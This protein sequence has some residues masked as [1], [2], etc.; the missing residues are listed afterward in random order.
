MT[1]EEGEMDKAEYIK[2]LRFLYNKALS[3]KEI[4]L[5]LDVLDR[6]ASTTLKN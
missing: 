3:N 5:A 1:K 2:E 4:A 6:I